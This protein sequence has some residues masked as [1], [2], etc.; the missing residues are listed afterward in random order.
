MSYKN[1]LL[2]DFTSES[3][4]GHYLKWAYIPD[5]SY[6]M[7]TIGGLRSRK[8]NK[9]LNLI[10]EQYYESLIDKIYF[11]A[12]DLNE[13]KYQL[14]IKKRENVGIKYLNDSK[15]FLE[16]SLCMEDV[17]NNIDDYNP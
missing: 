13:P 6:R 10:K 14:L 7:I 3:N 5:H 15:A 4:E 2:D 17:Y 8:T 16:Y 11:Y 12:K 1:Y 9:F